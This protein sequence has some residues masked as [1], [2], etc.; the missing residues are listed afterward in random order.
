MKDDSLARVE[1]FELDILFACPPCNQCEAK[2]NTWPDAHPK[3]PG[4]PIKWVDHMQR[5]IGVCPVGHCNEWP[6]GRLKP[7]R[8]LPVDITVRTLRRFVAQSDCVHGKTM[9]VEFPAGIRC[10]TI[11]GEIVGPGWTFMCLWC[12]LR[13]PKDE[14]AF[15]LYRP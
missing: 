2:L 12:G 14:V 7:L 5:F 11:K 10:N 9:E 4:K 13:W 8:I 15:R 1:E 3:V 6:I